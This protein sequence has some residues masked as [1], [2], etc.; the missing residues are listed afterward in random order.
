MAV[1]S[2]GSDPRRTPVEYADFG[3]PRRGGRARRYW[4]LLACL[5]IAAVVLAVRHPGKARRPAR[6]PVT[7]TEVARPL[8]GIRAGWELFGLGPDSV[9]AIQL[10]RGRVIQTAIP[11]PEGSGPV[12]FIVGPHSVIVRPL[13]DVPGYLV[14]D[15]QPAQPLTGILAR[16][17][18]LLPGPHPGQEWDAAGRANSLVLIGAGGHPAGAR[19]TLPGPS[20]P[21]RSAMSDGRGDV[22]VASDSGSQYDIGPHWLRRVSVLLSAVGPSRWLGVTC[23]SGRCRDVVLNPATGSQRTL[24]GPSL[25]LLTWPWPMYPGSVAPD[26]QTAAV[27]SDSGSGQVALEQ[28]NLVSGA[29][30]PIAVRLSETASGQTMAWSPDSQ[31]LFVIAASGKLLAVNVRSDKVHSLG[32][33]LPAL[34][35]LAIRGAA[36]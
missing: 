27:V 31:W 26:G 28:V 35:Q 13:D 18:L 6:P 20:W 32:V 36:G 25:H 24:P 30:R 15:G 1:S 23:E 5:L 8:L 9:V 19:I 34:S 10:A 2:G 17:G 12:S 22:L 3:S 33:P 4:L 16:G 14:P 21:S 11:P 7:V 29:V